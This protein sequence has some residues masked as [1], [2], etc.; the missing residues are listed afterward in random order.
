MREY[1]IG[2]FA[3]YL[4]VTPDLLKHSEEQGI[5]HP[6]RSESGY[7]IYPFPKTMTLIE[8]IRL[9]NYGMTLREIG[10]ILTAHR[11]TDEAVEKRLSENMRCLWEEMLLDE[12][13]TEDYA[14]FQR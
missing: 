4:G 8:C 7:R 6:Q 3:K 13:L 10:E 5:I 9:R 1:R 12:A 11:L 14:R 2:E